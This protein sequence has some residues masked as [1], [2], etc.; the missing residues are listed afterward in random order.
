MSQE[1][2]HNRKRKQQSGARSV[3]KQVLFSSA[4]VICS[5]EPRTAIDL[6]LCLSCLPHLK[7]KEIP[8]RGKWKVL[9]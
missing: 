5:H 9:L 1:V 2:V 7:Q 3:S 4:A 8:E 6:S